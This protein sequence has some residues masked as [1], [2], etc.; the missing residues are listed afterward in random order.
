MKKLFLSL[1]A[2]AMAAVAMADVNNLANP[3]GE[4][5]RYIVK[6]DCE[7]DAWATSNNF[8]PGETFVFA[9]D[10]TGTVFVDAL[11]EAP[12]GGTRA[13][14][15]NIWTNYGPKNDATNRLKQIKG[16]IY[17][18]T[19]NFAQMLEAHE[20]GLG[21]TVTANDSIIYAYCQLFMFAYDETEAGL[22]WY[23]NAEYTI[24]P[25][26]DCLFATLPS[27]GKN[28][29]V[30]YTDDFN[31]VMYGM[32]EAGYAAPCLGDATAVENVATEAHTRKVIENGNLYMIKNGVRYNVLGAIVK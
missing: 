14:A 7:N 2:V 22:E 11:K 9:V 1:A 12:A 17:G 10:V 4:D 26:A 30:F 15:A 3:V 27:T 28:E 24:A 25:G 32:K 8:E 18:A 31:E 23:V 29:E 21:A 19:M 6:W 16:N 20:P 13:M 5:G